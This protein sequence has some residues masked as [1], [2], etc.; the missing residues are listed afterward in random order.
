MFYLRNRNM[1]SV[2]LGSFRIN[3]L[4][5]YNECRSLIG[6]TTLYQFKQ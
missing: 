1:Y 4:A 6:Y 3:L 2:F 5:F